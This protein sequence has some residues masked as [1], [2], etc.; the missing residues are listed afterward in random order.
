MECFRVFGTLRWFGK[1]EPH[2]HDFCRFTH[3]YFF[4]IWGFQ[5]LFN[6][7]V[8]DLFWSNIF[9]DIFKNNSLKS[10]FGKL[11][12]WNFGLI[13]WNF[14]NKKIN[15]AKLFCFKTLKYTYLEN[16]CLKTEKR[17]YFDILSLIKTFIHVRHEALK[18]KLNVVWHAQEIYRGFL[19]HCFRWFSERL[20]DTSHQDFSLWILEPLLKSFFPELACNFLL[21]NL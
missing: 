7:G 20:N 19:C 15:L 6:H 4:I 16:Q 1:I 9:L 13:S 11:R 12:Q 3:L 17:A 5:L 8:N 10:N 18:I 2:C 14:L 21:F